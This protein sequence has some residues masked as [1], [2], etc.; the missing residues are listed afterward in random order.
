MSAA[1]SLD[2]V[3]A[4]VDAFIDIGTSLKVINK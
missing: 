4:C 3:N 2:E 1:H